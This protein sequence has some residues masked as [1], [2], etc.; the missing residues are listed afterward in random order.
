MVCG[1]RAQRLPTRHHFHCERKGLS[2]AAQSYTIIYQGYDE[3]LSSLCFCVKRVSQTS[4][5]SYNLISFF[6]ELAQDPTERRAK[7]SMHNIFDTWRKRAR[8]S[9][10]HRRQVPSRISHRAIRTTYRPLYRSVFY[11]ALTISFAHTHIAAYGQLA[12]CHVSDI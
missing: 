1:T 5:C 11:L 9:A 12:K 7:A 2:R 10:Q 6:L 8:R 4:I 3:G